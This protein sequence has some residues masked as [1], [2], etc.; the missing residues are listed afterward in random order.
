MDNHVIAAVLGVETDVVNDALDGS[1]VLPAPGGG[2]SL[3]VSA[4]ASFDLVT[5]EV[6]PEADDARIVTVQGGLTAPDP[7]DAASLQ[8]LVAGIQVGAISILEGPANLTETLTFVVPPF[9]TWSVTESV[10]LN[11]EAVIGLC[12]IYTLSVG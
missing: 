12:H 11:G 7:T 4:P 10:A 3:A 5:G 2:G 1:G 6:Q 8:A 9:H